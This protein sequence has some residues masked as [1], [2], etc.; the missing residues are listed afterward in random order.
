MGV[1]TF[2]QQA[3]RARLDRLEP[4]RRAEFALGCAERLLPW[5]I[6]FHDETGKGDS[7]VPTVALQA[8]RAR[9]MSGEGDVAHLRSLADRCESLVPV[10]EDAWTE[11]SGV[12]QNAVAAV[13]YA[14]RC[15][16]SGDAQDA[17]WAAVQGYEAADLLAS[18]ELD[19]DFN[20]PGVEQ[21]IAAQAVVQAELT[22]QDESLC[23]LEE[24]GR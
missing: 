22:A 6:R 4:T 18:T 11:L 20:E 16:V 23:R 2:D 7:S 17:V 8:A 14:I 10:E 24:R 1:R 13:V 12:A 15:L 19:V 9:L 3:L 5:Y 21:R